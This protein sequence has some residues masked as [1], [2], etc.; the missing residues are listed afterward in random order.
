MIKAFVNG[1]ANFFDRL[2]RKYTPDPLLLALIL[3]LIVFVSGLFL[4]NTTPKG[5]ILHWGGGFW[6]L[7]NFTMQM[8]MIFMGGY[9]L[10]ATPCVRS[11]LSKGA[12]LVTTPGQAVLFVSLVSCV[13]C[14][15]NWGFG[16]VIGGFL[17][18]E[19]ARAVPKANFRLLVASAYSGFLLFHG[20][21]S[22]SIPLTIAT[23][24]NFTEKSL[25]G[26]IPLGE[27]LFAP[28]NVVAL[29]ALFILLPLVNWMMGNTEPKNYVTIIEEE[30][31]HE[32]EDKQN[33]VPAERLENSRLVTLLAGGMG[34]AYI[35]FLI[36]DKTVTFGL[37]FVTFLFLFLALFLHK[38]AKEFIKAVE[39]GASRVG[40]ILIQFP[41]YAGIMG[42][43]QGSGLDK[44]IASAYVQ[45][46]TPETFNLLTFYTAG[47][48]NLFI[49]SGGGQWAVQA[50]IVIEAAKEL[51][52]SLPM[53]AMAVAWGDAWT[54]MIQPFWALP[55]LAIAGLKLREIMGYCVMALL[56]SGIVMTVV[57][58][59]F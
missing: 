30:D 28:F 43:L 12:K 41:F 26:L 44:V 14:W 3:T 17:C 50:P 46:A 9:V 39:G 33:M 5:M 15:I 36:I 27:T 40:P 45:I 52:T 32:V 29:I 20:G 10:A 47:F 11:I 18:R 37:D 55:L 38:N 16:L 23:P 24:G 25:G 2:M 34:L 49:P 57:F 53:A 19:L 31:Q 7:I 8:A 6:K 59:V 1:S 13:S 58:L 4:T 42:M 22:G 54:N 56:V 35:A 51:G 48:L 21:L